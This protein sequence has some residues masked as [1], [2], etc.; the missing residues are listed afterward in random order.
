[1]TAK[2][3]L[4]I[5]GQLT[6]IAWILQELPAHAPEIEPI[7]EDALKLSGLKEFRNLKFRRAKGLP[8]FGQVPSYPYADQNAIAQLIAR[9]QNYLATVPEVEAPIGRVL[10]AGMEYEAIDFPVGEIEILGTHYNA[11]LGE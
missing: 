4:D 3:P 10:P 5:G 2:P 8:V 1:M 7:L 6:W 9:I 11:P